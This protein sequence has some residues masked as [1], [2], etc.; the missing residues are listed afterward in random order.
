MGEISA[1][2]SGFSRENS[3]ID[4]ELG[5]TRA[6][7]MPSFTGTFTGSLACLWSPAGWGLCAVSGGKG[8]TRPH[9]TAKQMIGNFIWDLTLFACLLEILARV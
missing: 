1:R 8:K 9:F 5:D 2:F 4:G 6:Y 7:S 3:N